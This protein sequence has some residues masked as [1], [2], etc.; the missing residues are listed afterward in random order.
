MKRCVLSTFLPINST[1]NSKLDMS[2]KKI[3]WSLYYFL[4]T[5]KFRQLWKIALLI[6]LHIF[7][8]R[9]LSLLWSQ[10]YK[11]HE[12]YVQNYKIYV[13]VIG[14]WPFFPSR[15]HIKCMKCE[16]F[17]EWLLWAFIIKRD[18]FV[19]KWPVLW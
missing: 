9:N 8:G 19:K 3:K 2:R 17:P 16:T 7:K 6:V 1:N 5:S 12:F 15:K 4:D 11:N 13:H 10:R 18:T 14:Y